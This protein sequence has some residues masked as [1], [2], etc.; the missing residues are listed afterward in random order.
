MKARLVPADPDAEDPESS[1][2]WPGDDVA[3]YSKCGRT[4]RG[5]SG[6]GQVIAVRLRSARPLPKQQNEDEAIEING[7]ERVAE[8]ELPA[9]TWDDSHELPYALI[10]NRLLP[11]TIRILA[12][13]ISPPLGFS[14]RF[15]C[16]ERQY[17]YFFTS[18]A[19]APL[20]P[21]LDINAMNEAAAHFLGEHDFRNLC[22]LDASK[23]ID[24]FVRKINHSRIHAC[25]EE[26]GGAFMPSGSELTSEQEREESVEIQ[27]IG[28]D[29]KPATAVRW[30]YFAL[31]G[32]GFLWHQVRHMIAV[33]FLVG[34][35][36]EPPRIV[37]DLL[38]VTKFPRKPMYEM[39]IDRPLVL[40]DCVFPD[41]MLN[42]EPADTIP[43]G[44]GA[45]DGVVDTVWSV[46]KRAK[47]D[48][49]LAGALMELAEKRG[50]GLRGGQ[51]TGMG[52]GAGRKQKENQIMVFGG[53]DVAY[54]GAYEPLE[55]RKTM[56][57]IK[58]INAAWVEK[59]GVYKPRAKRKA[60]EAALV[61]TGNEVE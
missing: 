15:N 52:R 28:N 3:E 26:S 31:H 34:Q 30:Y 54:R 29:K 53:E 51:E 27:R 17:R 2:A 32:S 48:E 5:V 25:E 14:A 55:K 41:G 18:P 16:V 44:P 9:N 8:K 13:C 59:K 37:S 39:A 40:W 23:Q 36:L 11:P 12:Y 38:D 4:D 58:E 21:P 6:F 33:L 24:N 7:E 50:G 43:V 46:W 47:L 42:W 60:E 45:R 56:R 57:D 20:F 22:K 61:D 49:V 1:K 35:H 19:L 10:L